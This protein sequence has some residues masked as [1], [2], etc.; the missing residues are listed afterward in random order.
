MRKSAPTRPAGPPPQTQDGR[1]TERVKGTLRPC[2]K[3]SP[4]CSPSTPRQMWRAMQHSPGGPGGRHQRKDMSFKARRAAN[5]RTA[6]SG[7]QAGEAQA[8]PPG[9]LKRKGGNCQASGFGA[10]QPTRAG[11]SVCHLHKDGKGRVSLLP[12]LGHSPCVG[13]K[14][15]C[16]R[17]KALESPNTQFFWA[18]F[19]SLLCRRVGPRD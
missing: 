18:L 6:L 2:P 3:P 16:S 15:S 11:P 1:G 10:E 5:L 14:G 17:V 8:R 12:D 13:A 7:G 19:P 9:T 4:A